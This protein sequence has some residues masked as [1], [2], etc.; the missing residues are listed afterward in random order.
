MRE[1]RHSIYTYLN[2]PAVIP[3]PG[4]QKMS[5][6]LLLQLLAICLIAGFAGGSFSGIL[7]K[8]HLIP[9]P[10]PS[11]L[12]RKNLSPFEFF[13]GAVIIAP[14]M[15]ELIFRAQ[16]RRFSVSLLFIAFVCGLILSGIVHSAWGFLIS[17][18]VFGL[19]FLIY[20]FTLAGSVSRKFGFWRKL[21]PW[22]FHFTA[23]CFALVHLANFEKGISLLPLGILYTL[24]QLFIGLVLGYTRMNYGLRYA[25]LLH[26]LYNLSF[27]LLLFSKL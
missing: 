17:P 11:V 1:L 26:S 9:S 25:V 15:E 8:S 14:V 10:G 18:I 3:L 24:P 12:D 4:Q 27:A 20:R 7:I 16:L 13:M 23:L 19:I 5:V 22:H 21:F 6:M 2:S